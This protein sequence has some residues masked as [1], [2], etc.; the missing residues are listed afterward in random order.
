MVHQTESLWVV[1]KGL[2]EIQGVS[3]ETELDTVAREGVNFSGSFISKG[4]VG[5][6]PIGVL[7]VGR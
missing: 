4:I 2:K 3:I 1:W 6:Q 7:M 5:L